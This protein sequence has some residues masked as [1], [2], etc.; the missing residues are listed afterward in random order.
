[1]CALLLS[2]LPLSYAESQDYNEYDI[3]VNV[4]NSAGWTITRV[5]DINA[6]IDV[7]GFPSRVAALID[8]AVDQ[9][10]REMVLD[11]ESLQVSDE[12]SWETQSR[13]TVY[14][15]TWQNFSVTE[16]GKLTLGDVFGVPGFF[17]SLFGEGAIQ[18]TYPSDY[19]V[20]LVSPEPNEH[21]DSARTLRWFRTQD[22]VNGK[23]SMTFAEIQNGSSYE[24]QQYAVIGAGLTVATAAVLLGLYLIRIRKPRTRV[25]TRE[26][27][28]RIPLMESDEEKITKIIRSSGGNMRQSAITEQCGFSKAKTSQLLAV[29]EQKQVITR[30]KK[31][32]DKIVTLNERAAGEKS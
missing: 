24:W 9:T 20:Q 15:F 12:V 8:A 16:N 30:Y 28:A 3:E 18:I 2:L 14:S 7:E 11:T 32:R 21:D 10:Q 5:T 6:S 29:L 22:F 31:G 25:S 26:T 1:V 27:S 23:P 17:S 13:T 4:D 19:S